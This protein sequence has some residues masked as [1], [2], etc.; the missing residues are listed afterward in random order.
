[1]SIFDDEREEWVSDDEPSYALAQY[2][3]NDGWI[4]VESDA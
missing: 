4:E 2:D 1:M 3:P